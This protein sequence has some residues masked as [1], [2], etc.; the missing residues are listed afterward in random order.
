MAH[1]PTLFGTA[2]RKRDIVDNMC[3]TALSRGFGSG[4]AQHAAITAW[5]IC[6]D[7]N[8]DGCTMAKWCQPCLTHDSPPISTVGCPRRTDAQTTEFTVSQGIDITQV[9]SFVGWYCPDHATDTHDDVVVMGMLSPQSISGD[10]HHTASSS[11]LSCAAWSTPPQP[12]DH[13]SRTR[14]ER[15]G[16]ASS[17]Q[18]VPNN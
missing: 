12:A 15:G 11:A 4:V 2:T 10:A 17:S 7:L 1:I 18:A 5:A 16:P 6:G 8:T 14:C 3:N 13:T 9:Q